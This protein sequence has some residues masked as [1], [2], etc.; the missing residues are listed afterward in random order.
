MLGAAGKFPVQPEGANIG[1]ILIANAMGDKSRV[2]NGHKIL[3]GG[4]PR[5]AEAEGV[6]AHRASVLKANVLQDTCIAHKIHHSR[7]GNSRMCEL[8]CLSEAWRDSKERQ[9]RHLHDGTLMRIAY[10]NLQSM[11]AS[12]GGTSNPF[13]LAALLRANEP[14][15]G[16]VS[17]GGF[18]RQAGGRAIP[19]RVNRHSSKLAPSESQES[20]PVRTTL[21]AGL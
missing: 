16:G 14:F 10:G 3:S 20:V 19:S 15:S 13:A 17:S 5:P 18:L 11:C 8:R 4:A 1:P 6:L 9:T 12:P 7:T 21:F 2:R